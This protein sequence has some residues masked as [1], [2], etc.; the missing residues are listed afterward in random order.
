MEETGEQGTV[1]FLREDVARR[2]FC[3]LSC[4][5]I[6]LEFAFGNEDV[7]DS[8]EL[9][10]YLATNKATDCFFAD[11][12]FSC[13]IFHVEG[14]AF[15]GCCCIHTL[16]FTR[17]QATTHSDFFGV[18]DTQRNLLPRGVNWSSKRPL[19]AIGELRTPTFR[20]VAGS[21]EQMC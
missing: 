13:A 4:V 15:G 14:L 19:R 10:K 16:C 11:T 17:R 2:I 3:Q 9:A 21:A 5:Q 6:P 1:S 18:E 20:F 7:A 12:Q 8:W